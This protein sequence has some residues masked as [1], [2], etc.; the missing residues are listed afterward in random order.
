[1]TMVMPLFQGHNVVLPDGS[2]TA[3]H[4]PVLA[5]TGMCRAALRTLD[6]VSGGH[7][8]GF[9]VADLGCCE[10]GYSAEFAR[11]GYEVTGIEVRETNIKRCV[12][13]A[14]ELQLPNLTFAQD[15]ARNLGAHGTFDAVFCAGLLS[16][17]ENPVA[18]I[19]TLGAAARQ[20]LILS[21]HYSVKPSTVHE[22]K[23]GSWF[24]DF[25]DEEHI[26]AAWRT[27]RAFWLAKNAILDTVRGAGF[28]LIYEQ[29]DYLPDLLKGPQGKP[30]PDNPDGGEELAVIVAV[31]G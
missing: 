8:A 15:D 4:L 19:H 20:V 13:L 10:G 11:A 9:T 16:H 17:M 18:F 23:I 30:A 14:G 25:D 12:W 1:M 27:L 3:P 2:Q 22:G 7:R 24:N 26:F 29:Y 28:P 5:A 31:K 6:L 21:T